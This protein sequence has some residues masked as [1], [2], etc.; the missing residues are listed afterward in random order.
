MNA[1]A[2]TNEYPICRD[3]TD[4]ETRHRW[5]HINMVQPYDY[6]QVLQYPKV[7]KYDSDTFVRTGWDS[8]VGRMY[9]RNHM[10][11]AKG[12]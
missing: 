5:I 2:A 7:L 12:A 4:P 1:T 8:D 9:Y 10:P 11:V 3:W 6:E